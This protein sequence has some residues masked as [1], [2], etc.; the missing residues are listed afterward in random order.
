MR[1]L[2]FYILLV[3]LFVAT[4]SHSQNNQFKKDSTLAKRYFKLFQKYEYQ[5]TLK[6]RMYSDS[7]IYFAY[8]TKDN[9]LI[10]RAHQFKGWFFQDC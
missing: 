5:D 6:A 10:G 7:A 4:D 3:L 8:K 9:D 1:Q 2:N